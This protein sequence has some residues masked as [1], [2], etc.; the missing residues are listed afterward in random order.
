MNF[1]QQLY[2]DHQYQSD[3]R[4]NYGEKRSKSF[5][6]KIM[7]RFNAVVEYRKRNAK[8]FSRYQTHSMN[9]L[10]NFRKTVPDSDP[11]EANRECNRHPSPSCIGPARKRVQRA[12]QK[13][14]PTISES[15]KTTNPPS[16]YLRASNCCQVVGY[17][18]SR[19]SVATTNFKRFQTDSLESMPL[20]VADPQIAS[21]TLESN[22]RAPYL[23]DC[24]T[25]MPLRHSHFEASQTTLPTT[26]IVSDSELRAP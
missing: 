19:E 18:T 15:L 10:K 26:S 22:L 4:R 17:D 7:S 14:A 2:W 20:S 25:D 5:H 24:S 16:P 9:N 23:G 1:R 13:L 21:N 8:W 12:S 11:I 3:P 6:L